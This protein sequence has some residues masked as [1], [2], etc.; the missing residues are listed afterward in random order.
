MLYTIGEKM[1]D[2]EIK[3]F[4]FQ[5]ENLELIKEKMLVDSE[6]EQK[7]FSVLVAIDFDYRILKS[8][9]FVYKKQ[10]ASGFSAGYYH[11]ELE[12]CIIGKYSKLSGKQAFFDALD[13]EEFH[14][15]VVEKIT[16]AINK[17]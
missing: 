3:E 9:L 8:R 2:E 7:L 14:K 10:N 17:I 11:F 1:E 12:P 15:D 6:K 13:N 4:L 16:E 5:P